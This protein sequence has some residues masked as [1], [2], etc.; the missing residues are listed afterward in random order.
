MRIPGLYAAAALLI[1]LGAP[2]GRN[3]FAQTNVTAEIVVQSPGAKRTQKSPLATVVWLDPIDVA[4]GVPAP[5]PRQDVQLVQRN[6]EFQPHV[7]VVPVGTAVE[8]PNRDPFFHN[9]FSLF[10]GKRFDLGLYEAGS[11][12]MVHFDRPGISYIFCNIHSQMNAVVIALS[13]PY[14]A[15]AAANGAVVLAGVRPGRY[16]LEVWHEGTS[17]EALRLLSRVVEVRQEEVA[18]GKIT[19]VQDNAMLVHK[20]KYGQD[21]V[22]PPRAA[23]EQR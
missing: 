3:A 9:V 6:K 20:N 7:L 15:L 14:H 19:V 22:E 8:F 11:S 13:T 17:P 18:L 5:P 10:E 12:R 4:G 21:Y 1:C 2:G 23:Y 16:R